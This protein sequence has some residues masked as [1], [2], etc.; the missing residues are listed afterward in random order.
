MKEQ[1]ETVSDIVQWILGWI[2]S[3]ESIFSGILAIVAIWSLITGRWRWIWQRIQQQRQPRPPYNTFAFDVLPPQSNILQAV[4]GGK[5]ENPLADRNIPYQQ[6][7]PDRNTR[8]QLQELLEEHRWILI[9]GATGIG[10]TREAAELAQTY[11]DR[12]WT[13]LKFDESK[14]LD[15]PSYALKE[16][17]GTDRKLLFLL[18]DLNKAVYRRDRWLRLS[19]SEDTRSTD[20]LQLPDIPLQ[21]RLLQFLEHCERNCRPEEVR[22]IAT[23]RDETEPERAGEPSEWDKLEFDRFPLWKRFHHHELP[24]PDDDAIVDLL[25]DTAPKVNMDITLEDRV[26]IARSNDRTFRNIVQ[27]LSDASVEQR[28]LTPQTFTPTLSG[29]WDKHYQ[30]AIGKHPAAIYVYDAIDLLR[31]TGIALYPFTVLPTA[32]LLV[33][34]HW[35]HHRL[36]HRPIHRVLQYLVAKEDILHPQDGQIEAKS[37]SV[38]VDPYLPALTELVLKLSDR[39]PQA[40]QESLLNFGSEIAKREQFQQALICFDQLLKLTPNSSAAWDWRG[41]S[42]H[43]LERYEEAIDNYD[44]SLKLKSDDY[45]TRCSRAITLFELKRY[46]EAVTSCD[47]ALDIKHDYDY[48]WN[49]RGIIFGSLKNYEEANISFDN[50]LKLNKNLDYVWS[51]KGT[52]LRML[53]R[54]DD[55]IDSYDQALNINPRNCNAWSGKAQALSRLERYEEAVSSY[56]RALELQPDDPDLWNNRGVVLKKLGRFKEAISSFKESLELQPDDNFA[57]LNKMFALSA[58]TKQ[59]THLLNQRLF[60]E[61]IVTFDEVIELEPNDSNAYYNKACCYGLQGNVEPAVENLQQAI[62]LDSN[63]REDA[64]TNTDFDRVRSDDRFQSLIH[65]AD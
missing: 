46:E 42:L 50:A 21:E 53:A 33:S 57:D 28:S 64:K 39:Y 37:R 51:N 11:S 38:D 55:A 7:Q 32:R 23:A 13:V 34:K 49:L 65:D 2:G 61:A 58:L 44:R 5:D 25:R 3:N 20:A 36:K 54:Y 40:L 8:R 48:A 18:D 22:V 41:Y 14:W 15:Q 56:E 6:R 47:E 30:R 62:E 35:L 10:K 29:T 19:A 17:I 24:K 59:G 31:Q 12:G 27:N 16:K 9:T 60:E 26:R 4:Y 63:Y 43:Y 1:L 52:A 45:Q